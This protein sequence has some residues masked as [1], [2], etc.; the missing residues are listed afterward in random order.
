MVGR[1]RLEQGRGSDHIANAMLDLPRLAAVRQPA[2]LATQLDEKEVFLPLLFANVFVAA[3]V[4]VEPAPAK[5]LMAGIVGTVWVAAATSEQVPGDP[6][7]FGPAVPAIVLLV[8]NGVAVVI[9]AQRRV[10][11]RAVLVCLVS[12]SAPL[13]CETD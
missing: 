9:A 3:E 2:G 11:D 8:I 12:Q 6:S 1:S 10:T 4:A 5:P 13:S 7:P